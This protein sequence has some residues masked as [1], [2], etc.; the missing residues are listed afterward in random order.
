VDRLAQDIR[1]AL[2]TMRHSPAFT[3]VADSVTRARHSAPT[4]PSSA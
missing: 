3:A 2:R 1:Y 4:R